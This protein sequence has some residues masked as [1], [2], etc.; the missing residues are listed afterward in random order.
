MLTNKAGSPRHNSGVVRA[1]AFT[2]VIDWDETR[3]DRPLLHSDLPGGGDLKQITF[4]GQTT[5]NNTGGRLENI[6]DGV[7]IHGQELTE[8]LSKNAPAIRQSG[9]RVYVVLVAGTKA[10]K[11]FRFSAKELTGGNQAA[12]I[13]IRN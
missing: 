8:F 3:S 2:K 10:E 7:R 4:V 9:N 5:I 13:A 12:A 6:L 11:G 1:Y